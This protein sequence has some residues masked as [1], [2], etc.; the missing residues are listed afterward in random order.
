MDNI[1]IKPSW[2]TVAMGLGG[3]VWLILWWTQWSGGYTVAQ[4][5][6][7]VAQNLAV[8][9]V[10]ILAVAGLWIL[11][12]LGGWPLGRGARIV[13][14]L[15]TGLGFGL[16]YLLWGPWKD[17]GPWGSLAIVIVVVIVF[18]LVTAPVWI[19]KV[20]TWT[21]T[22]EVKVEVVAEGTAEVTVEGSVSTED[23]D[24]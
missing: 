15:V 9:L 3:L 6:Y 13:I 11:L 12:S 16:A 23:D 18:A 5:G 21:V 17:M 7:T 14:L 2:R 19:W 8:T 22:S 10:T 24:R 20:M 1:R 4:K